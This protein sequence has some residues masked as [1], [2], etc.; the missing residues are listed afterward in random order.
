MLVNNIMRFNWMQNV[1]EIWTFYKFE[2]AEYSRTNKI[3]NR[4]NEPNFENI[5][6]NVKYIHSAPIFTIVIFTNFKA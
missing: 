5:K 3:T 1:T 6:K 4:K 2:F